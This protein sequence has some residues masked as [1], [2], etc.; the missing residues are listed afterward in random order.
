MIRC[1]GEISQSKICRASFSDVLL[2]GCRMQQVVGDQA[3]LGGHRDSAVDYI[4]FG[5]NQEST[6]IFV[7]FKL[8]AITL[9]TMNKIFNLMQ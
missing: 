7:F 9:Q 8:L 6:S 1:F 2:S 3:R 4:A 5:P